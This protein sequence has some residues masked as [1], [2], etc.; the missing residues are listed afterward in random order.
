MIIDS[1]AYKA[2]LAPGFTIVAVNGRAYQIS[3]LRAAIRDAKGSGPA[4][5]LI[6][7]NTG[8]YKV[9]HIDYHEGERYPNL[10]RVPGTADRL[11]DILQS[12]TK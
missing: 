4:L 7:A 6:V 12:M 1:P 9:L 5:E 2:G 3:L 11:D 8:Y 10:E